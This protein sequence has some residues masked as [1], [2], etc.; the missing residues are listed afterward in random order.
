MRCRSQGEKNKTG[1]KWTCTFGDII[2]ECL[3]V[4]ERKFLRIYGAIYSNG[5]WIIRYNNELKTV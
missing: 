1:I 3:K 4:S 5:N 2:C